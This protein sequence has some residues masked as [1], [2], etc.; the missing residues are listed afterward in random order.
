[1]KL[2]VRKDFYE[3]HLGSI[4]IG[5]L[6]F[7]LINSFFNK[8]NVFFY[9]E[10]FI[11]PITLFLKLV[12]LLFF[13]GIIIF[14][15]NIKKSFFLYL[16]S[17]FIVFFVAN[18]KWPL[19]L[20]NGADF[21]DSLVEGNIFYFIKYL[22]PF[23]FLKAFS[24][25]KNKEETICRY[26]DILEKVLVVN[27]ILVFFGF[28]FSIDFF[29]SYPHSLRF[30]YCGLLE[31]LFVFYLSI[32]VMSR[33]FLF[34][35]I[36]LRF[37]ILC[38]ASLLS[39]TKGMLLFFALLILYYICTKRTIKR[40]LFVFGIFISMLVFFKP[41]VGFTLKLFPFWQP[42]LDKY[43]YITFLFST[44]DLTFKRTFEHLKIHGT[45]NNLFIGGVDFEKYFIE[46]DF[47]DLF[48]FFGIIGGILYM[49]LLSKIINK[50][51]HIIPLIVAFF[52]GSLLLGS[53]FMCTYLLWLYESNF[54]K[55]KLF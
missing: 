41:I 31:R 38:L 37:M 48:L 19:N 55:N 28:I 17:L 36:D 46:L 18:I 10:N 12:F 13:G 11:H 32:I 26:F 16:G 53:I 54:E 45:L 51:Y 33:K 50:S 20:N 40:L 24:L 21:Y 42:I 22:Y 2:F 34:E 39:G 29:Q 35:K 1:M 25:V 27:S 23:I 44:R 4:L 43:G 6:I 14:N 15:C 30:G 52:V 3:H 47:I 9:G 5:S 7:Y 49:V 8:I